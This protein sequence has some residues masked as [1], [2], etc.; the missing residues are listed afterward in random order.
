M[1]VQYVTNERG[2]KTAIQL[3][4]K[5]WEE[6]QKGIKKLELFEDLKQA[7]KEMEHHKKGTLKTIS[8]KQLLSQL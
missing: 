2:K 3:P 6:L 1:Q 4:L 5:Q 8:T 7:F